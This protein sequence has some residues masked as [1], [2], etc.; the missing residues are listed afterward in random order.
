MQK[1]AGVAAV[2]AVVFT[3]SIGAAHAQ[4]D[5]RGPNV[6]PET[7]QG[8]SRSQSPAARGPRAD[9]PPAGVTRE[10]ERP[11]TP[12]NIVGDPVSTSDHPVVPDG[13]SGRRS[14]GA[15]NPGL[16]RNCPRCVA[17]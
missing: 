1:A 7:E 6:I 9:D 3:C 11:Q 10:G 12:P 16:T 8:S 14:D 17:I 13:T 2:I 5:R 4:T 15:A